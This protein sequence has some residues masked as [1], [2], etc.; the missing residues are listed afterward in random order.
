MPEPTTTTTEAPKPLS[1]LQLAEARIAELEHA[2]EAYEFEEKHRAA[3]EAER[4]RA[5]ESRGDPK[6][7]GTVQVFDTD[8]PEDVLARAEKLRAGKIPLDMAKR[9]KTTTF[10]MLARASML[11]KRIGAAPAIGTE[12]DREGLDDEK[13]LADLAALTATGDIVAIA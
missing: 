7:L 11:A 6:L 10:V 13:S 3:R 1:K 2:I 5:R 9:F 12:F 4:K 8:M